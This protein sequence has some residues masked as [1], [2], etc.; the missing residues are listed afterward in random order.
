MKRKTLIGIHKNLFFLIKFITK[1]NSGSYG[2]FIEF[3]FRSFVSF[4]P[5]V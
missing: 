5:E 4:D 3:G 1:I 2:N